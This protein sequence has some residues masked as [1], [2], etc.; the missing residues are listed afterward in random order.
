MDKSSSNVFVNETEEMREEVI[1]INEKR[2]YYHSNESREEEVKEAGL[3]V[4]EEKKDDW[5]EIHMS[6]ISNPNNKISGIDSYIIPK[7]FRKKRGNRGGLLNLSQPESLR[8]FDNVRT[9]NTVD[10]VQPLVSYYDSFAG[11]K[12]YETEEVQSDIM[13]TE[14]KSIDRMDTV[15][16]HRFSYE[17]MQDKPRL[18]QQKMGGYVYQSVN[19]NVEVYVEKSPKNFDTEDYYFYKNEYYRQPTK[20]SAVDLRRENMDGYL[21]EGRKKEI[22]LK[23]HKMISY[24]YEGEAQNEVDWEVEKRKLKSDCRRLTVSEEG[25]W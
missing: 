1:Q 4:P 23:S 12:N 18:T 17:K 16:V 20:P 19:K 2:V 21:Y 7:D 13:M 8:S 9:E 6:R 5:E 14:K 15:G 25:L 24:N 22:L 3:A 10:L 11:L